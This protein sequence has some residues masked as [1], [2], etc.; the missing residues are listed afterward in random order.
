[1]IAR[2][3]NSG[4]IAVAGRGLA[5]IPVRSVPSW[6]EAPPEQRVVPS[7]N[8]RP[9]RRARLVRSIW[10]RPEGESLGEKL[11]MGLLA[12]AG[13]ACIGYGFSSL[14]DLVQHWALFST[15]ISQMIQ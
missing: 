4:A 7:T 8:L 13:V 1:M 5:T 10:I 15:G 12:V 11:V 2:F 9:Q 14:V 3:Q 6:R